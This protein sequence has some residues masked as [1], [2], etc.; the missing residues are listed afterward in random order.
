[1]QTL[2]YD[3]LLIVIEAI[4][5]SA[6]SL[7]FTKA[8]S[9]KTG[10]QVC[11]IDRD[12]VSDTIVLVPIPVE[13]ESQKSSAL[14]KHGNQSNSHAANTSIAVM[15]LIAFFT[16][17]CYLRYESQITIGIIVFFIVLESFC[18]TTAYLTYKKYA[19]S[20]DTKKRVLFNL[21]GAS[22]AVIGLLLQRHPICG[23][24]VDK[25]ECLEILQNHGIAGMLL[26][27]EDY[28]YL[29]AQAAGLVFLVLYMLQ[30]L[31]GAL[32]ILALI[33][34]A[35]GKRA[36]KLW[37]CIWK[38]TDKDC[39]RAAKYYKVCII[40]MF[41]SFCLVSGLFIEFVLNISNI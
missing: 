30:I 12:A 28:L 16:V 40:F 20:I 41:I 14:D 39:G 22:I 4:V 32:H 18:L 7:L 24:E 27:G 8:L 23:A 21:I 13:K 17:F 15:I 31:K 6:V 11:D 10:T 35:L 29:V 1:M 26:G 2:G 38:F 33:N 25:A 9:S 3:L 36:K 5:A 34:L 37:M 19:M